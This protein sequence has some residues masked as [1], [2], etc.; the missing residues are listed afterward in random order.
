MIVR[1]LTPADAPAIASL[2]AAVFPEDPWTSAMVAEELAAPGR[3]Y[4]GIEEE[5]TDSDEGAAA[6]IAYGGITLFQDSDL[7]TIGVLPDHR[8]KGLG[9]RLLQELL[10]RAADAKV[11]RMFLEV[12]AS[13]SAAIA[14]YA[15][16]GF[17]E[18]G[19]VRRYYR[20][21]VEDAVTMRRILRPA[22]P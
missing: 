8:G 5:E 17:A 4:L 11:A 16:E 9:R 10:A 12:R 18:L 6:L 15:S 19:R 2:E 20:N 22:A 3:C 21:P 7:M 14:L 13:N 1:E